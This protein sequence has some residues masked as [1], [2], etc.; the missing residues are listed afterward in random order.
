MWPV[1][2]CFSLKQQYANLTNSMSQTM[3]PKAAFLTTDFAAHFRISHLVCGVCMT[4]SFR[5]S[6]SYY[7]DGAELYGVYTTASASAATTSKVLYIKF[8]R[9]FLEVSASPNQCN[10]SLSNKK[11][12]LNVSKCREHIAD[13]SGVCRLTYL[14]WPQTCN[15]PSAIQRGQCSQAK[16]A[17]QQPLHP[18]ASLYLAIACPAAAYQT[19]KQLSASARPP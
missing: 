15:H 19:H 3:K 6:A 8:T 5:H 9:V 17:S 14:R 7:V 11:A 16:G 10:K 2:A 4:T 18:C 12:Y 1:F 13:V